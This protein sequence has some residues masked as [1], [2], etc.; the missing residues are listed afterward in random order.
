MVS[1]FND[2][3]VENTDHHHYLLSN[4]INDIYKKIN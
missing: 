2:K 1:F 3:I 4:L